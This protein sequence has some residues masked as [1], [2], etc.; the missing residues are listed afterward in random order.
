MFHLFVEPAEK[1]PVKAIS[2]KTFYSKP[3]SR[4]KGASP[5]PINIQPT[6]EGN[7]TDPFEILTRLTFVRTDP[8]DR[9]RLKM[10]IVL[11]PEKV[12]QHEQM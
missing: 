2:G 8:F 11:D 9:N 7:L 5:I 12:A 1:E 4:P 3:P 6:T 10:S